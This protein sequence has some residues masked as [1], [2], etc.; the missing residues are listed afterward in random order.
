[1][2]IATIDFDALK[3][4]LTDC[5]NRFEI[6]QKLI[7]Q[8]KVHNFMELGVFKGELTH[9]LLSKNPSILNY[10]VVDPWR[11]LQNWN[12]PFNLKN[13]EFESIYKDFLSLNKSFLDRIVILRKMTSEILESDVKTPIDCIYI[14]GDHT[15]RGITIDLIKSW[16]LLGDYGL[17]IGDDLS[18]SIWQHSSKFE[19]TCVFPWVLYFAEAR[20]AEIVLLPYNQFVILKKPHSRFSV[21][22]Y[23]LKR[24]ENTTLLSQLN[25]K[26]ENIKRSKIWR[27]FND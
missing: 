10:Y 19:P 1:M 21:L 26:E 15:L 17:I 11:N 23:S 3:K 20:G 7:T 25:T 18:E 27:F 24:Y 6:I 14:D 8:F 13:N 2:K 4:D 9:Y 5:E 12:K 22:N 16:D